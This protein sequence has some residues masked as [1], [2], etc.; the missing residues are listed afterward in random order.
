MLH[1]IDVE[2]AQES[3]DK[4]KE[5]V[6]IDSVCL[7][8]NQSVIMAYLD[9]FAGK[10]KVKMPYKIDVGSEGRHHATLH[11]QENIYKKPWWNNLSNL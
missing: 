3:Q 10:I 9:T 11:I 5:I 6:S 4:Q 2:V 1:E 7:N 8:R